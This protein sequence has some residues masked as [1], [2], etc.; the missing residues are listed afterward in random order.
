MS[1]FVFNARNAVFLLALIAFLFL[2][3]CVTQP[4]FVPVPKEKWSGKTTGAVKGNLEFIISRTEN[5]NGLFIK[6]SFLI[7]ITDDAGKFHG[8]ALRG[9]MDGGIA[10]GILDL[11]L[12]GHSKT[13]VDSKELTGKMI[14][15][16]AEEEG[17]GPWCINLGG[18]L[19]F[20]E[21]SAKK[22]D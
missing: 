3:G 16:L 2:S 15:A 11:D 18:D 12:A 6:G 9:S 7:N 8:D 19:I 1:G 14:G 17:G 10:N 21:W 22:R 13:R 4:E 5:E 20:G